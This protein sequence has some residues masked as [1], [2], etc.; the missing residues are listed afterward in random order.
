MAMM[1][2]SQRSFHLRLSFRIADAQVEVHERD[3][4]TTRSYT[5]PFADIAW[6]PVEVTN[7]GHA[8]FFSGLLFGSLTTIIF[9]TGLNSGQPSYFWLSVFLLVT[10]GCIYFFF[11]KR[12][13][14]IVFPVASQEPQNPL[15]LIAHK[16][17]EEQVEAFLATLHEEW[18]SFWS[19]QVTYRD[20]GFTLTEELARLAW[21]KDVGAISDGE[22][23]N[24]KAHVLRDLGQQKGGL[25]FRLDP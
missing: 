25:G 21:L 14:F 23:E 12:T 24:L 19:N 4:L 6:R 16:P 17:S 11:F 13:P 10:L 20:P 9:F 18:Q 5:V 15:V 8:F 3:F 22:F 2:L 7:P 1:T